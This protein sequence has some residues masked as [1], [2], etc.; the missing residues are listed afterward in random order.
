MPHD[1]LFDGGRRATATERIYATATK[2]I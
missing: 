2:L 1:W